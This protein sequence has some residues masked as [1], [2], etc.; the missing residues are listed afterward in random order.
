MPDWAQP[1]YDVGGCQLTCHEVQFQNSEICWYQRSRFLTLSF[2]LRMCLQMYSADM[3]QR[4]SIFVSQTQLIIRIAN[5]IR[6]LHVF[7][8]SAS[9]SSSSGKRPVLIS[10]V[11]PGV[12]LVNTIW[13]SYRTTCRRFI[14]LWP[15]ACS[16]LI[17]FVLARFCSAL[18]M[19]GLRTWLSW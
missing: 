14:H 13:N 3:L 16:V 8:T 4:R 17:C 15:L 5:S 2:F 7:A 18:R 10:E 12:F 19:L 9:G 1:F 11:F 6:A